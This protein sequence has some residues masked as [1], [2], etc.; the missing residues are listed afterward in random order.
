MTSRTARP[1][2]DVSIGRGRRSGYGDWY[3]RCRSLHAPFV[4][5]RRMQAG[6]AEL[7]VDLWP[8]SPPG[9]SG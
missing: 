7:D 9:E 6:L 3:E 1:F 4:Y 8:T 2:A 5:V